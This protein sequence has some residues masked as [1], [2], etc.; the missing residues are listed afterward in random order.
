MPST[1]LRRFVALNAV[2]PAMLIS[3]PSWAADSSDLE[4][5]H[6][7]RQEAFKR[8]QV[9]EHVF[10]MTDVFGPRLT[11]SPGIHEAA[12]W[13]LE[14][15]ESWGLDN[16]HLEPWGPY[17]RGWSASYF[18]AHLIEPQYAPLIGVPLNWAPGTNGVVSGTPMLAALDWPRDVEGR[19]RALDEFIDEYRGRL[20]DRIVMMREPP[21]LKEVEKAMSVRFGQDD[22]RQRAQAPE[23][24]EPIEIDYANP[25]VP[26]NPDERARFMAHA[27][28]YV[29]ERIRRERRK[30]LYELNEF[31]A[32]E[33]VRLAIYPAWR[34]DGGTIFPPTVGWH[35]L[36]AV[37]PPPSIA[38]TPEHYNRLARLVEKG[39]P[40]RIDVEVR[41]Q[42]H[43]EHE[44]A[45]VVAE[46]EGNGKSDELVIIGAHFDD[47]V[48]G[49]GATDNATGCAVMMEV[50]RILKRLDLPLERTVRMVLWTGEEQGLLGSKAYVKQHFG[51][52][53]TMQLKP[54]QA[55]VSA[56]YNLDNGT[57]KIRG[58]YLQENDM[59]RP[60]FK[61]WLEPFT[62]LDAK[63][64]TIR[65]TGGTD[66]LSFD[67]VGIPGFQFIQ[68]PVEYR[69]RTHHSNMDVYDRV[70]AGDLMQ[71]SAIIASF[72][73]Q[74]ANRDDLLPRK[75]LPEPW[76]AEARTTPVAST[77]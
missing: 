36:D 60:I 49:T 41:A 77:R 4:V 10:H 71:A 73:Y 25:K 37:T 13:V 21:N 2:L 14:T 20:A 66:H 58:V 63:T 48:Y 57:G 5:V 18:S 23:P 62:D 16:A 22:L 42:F 44:P 56:Y 26:E 8:S 27:P 51:D 32:E 40:C 69:S 45:N 67:Q 17:G 54:E 55:M 28:R 70:Q 52:P 68:D 39:K 76:P 6:Q 74:T 12:Q 33:G 15:A 3:A 72:V 29:L 24:M 9:M 7:I 43:E 38:L 65:K 64:L 31:L 35:E 53:Q 75:P 46:I 50:M 1:R 30:L 59:V 61:K 11:R 34:G 47:V 19:R